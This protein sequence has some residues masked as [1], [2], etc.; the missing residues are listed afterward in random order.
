MLPFNLYIANVTTTPATLDLLLSDCNQSSNFVKL[1]QLCMLKL[2]LKLVVIMM[3]DWNFYHL[4]SVI[5]IS[6][7]YLS[8]GNYKN[9]CEWY[10]AWYQSCVE[11]QYTWSQVWEG[12]YY[13]AF[14]MYGDIN[15]C[16]KRLNLRNTMFL[17]APEN[18][19]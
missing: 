16:F 3:L 9:H 13:L 1:V 12:E 6:L 4:L 19:F 17:F 2:T 7:I 14:P 10:P 8:S 11:L 18:T 5:K 15:A